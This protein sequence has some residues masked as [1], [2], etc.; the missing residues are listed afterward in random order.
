M[1]LSA[2]LWV[3]WGWD[4][5]KPPQAGSSPGPECSLNPPQLLHWMFVSSQG[6]TPGVGTLSQAW[7][8]IWLHPSVPQL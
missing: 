3:F 1:L 8:P 6:G 7:V 5:W 2:Q 4:T